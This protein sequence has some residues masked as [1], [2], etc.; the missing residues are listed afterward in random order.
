MRNRNMGRFCGLAILAGLAVMPSTGLAL[1]PL[2]ALATP[3]KEYSNLID[4]NA[5]GAPVPGQIVLWAGTGAAA[6]DG[7]LAAGRGEVDALAN[8]GDAYFQGVLDNTAALLFSVQ[9]DAPGVPIQAENDL[10]VVS[11]WATAADVNS[12]PGALDDLD[13]LEV[14]GSDGVSDTTHY[15]LF[16]DPGGVA[17][18]DLGG[19]TVATT[20]DIAAMIGAPGM[21]VDL[22]ALMMNG[23]RILFSIRPVAGFFDGGE[24]WIGDLSTG[25]ASFLV[26]GGHTWDTA[27][28]VGAHTGCLNENIDALE[29]T[30]LVPEPAS[31]TALALGALAAIR[32]RNKK[33]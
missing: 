25:V 12:T 20:A 16:G 23:S 18:F 10:G 27:F 19:A 7:I 2:S 13:G 29:A 26:H 21:N 1:V 17:I 9:A 3:G 22:D 5:A 33:A 30:A 6:D 11:T 4:K 15:S 24:I 32:R 31:M 8:I 28:D 14:W